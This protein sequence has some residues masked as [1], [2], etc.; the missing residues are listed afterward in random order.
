MSYIIPWYQQVPTPR[1]CGCTLGRNGRCC[2]DQRMD[3]QEFGYMPYA[4]VDTST[5]K[6]TPP[7]VYIPV[8]P[9]IRVKAGRQVIA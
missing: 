6:L 4:P 3:Y 2:M 1:A 7:P 8:K 9:R 5:W